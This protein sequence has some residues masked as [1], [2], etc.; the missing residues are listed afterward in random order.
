M[1]KK[2]RRIA[3][4]IVFILSFAL[5]F[6]SQVFADEVTI[7]GKVNDNYQIVTEDSI[8]Y[9]VANTEMGIDLL[10]YVDKTVKVSGT[11]VEEEGVKI[12]T[13]T[14]FEVIEST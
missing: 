3:A 9:E 4:R 7:I 13:V 2:S 11:V 10:N 12:I 5:I 8:V 6:S 14:F 1:N